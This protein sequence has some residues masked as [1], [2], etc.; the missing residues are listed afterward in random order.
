MNP[1]YHLGSKPLQTPIKMARLHGNILFSAH[2]NCIERKLESIWQAPFQCSWL[3]S[4]QQAKA[5]KGAAMLW[6]RREDV[7]PEYPK[8]LHH[9]SW[10]SFD[11]ATTSC[12]I[13]S[14][15]NY[16]LQVTKDSN[17]WS[18]HR[19][20][21]ASGPSKRDLSLHLQCCFL[22][23]FTTDYISKGQNQ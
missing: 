20:R 17:K 5:S 12:S 9:G 11:I 3:W 13:L 2:S 1:A 4:S 15:C 7:L 18:R 21:G 16:K 23:L 8:D 10:C 14:L 6:V 22:S 19:F